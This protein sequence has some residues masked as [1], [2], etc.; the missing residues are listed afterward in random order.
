MTI[1]AGAEYNVPRPIESCGKNKCVTSLDRAETGFDYAS[2][3]PVSCGKQKC[4]KTCNK[5][6][7]DY[8]GDEEDYSCKSLE[9]EYGCD[10]FGCKC[11][12]TTCR[13]T[14]NWPKRSATARL[15]T[16]G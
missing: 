15:A 16:S 1:E 10:C 7:C 14:T 8:W 12:S 13:A 11:K 2:G 3:R 6:T 9:E 5:Q 4:A